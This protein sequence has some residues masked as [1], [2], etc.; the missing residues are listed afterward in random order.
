MTRPQVGV[1]RELPDK[2][3]H[4]NSLGISLSSKHI[5]TS[6]VV[7]RLLFFI[8]FMMAK[9]LVFK[10]SSELERWEREQGKLNETEL[11]V[12]TESHV[13]FS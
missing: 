3:N 7:S 8:A 10:A 1:P 5:L 6:P 9:L 11:T 13:F 2:S 12:L 4:D